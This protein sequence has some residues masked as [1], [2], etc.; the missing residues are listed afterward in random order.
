MASRKA[1]TSDVWGNGVYVAPAIKALFRLRVLFLFDFSW[2]GADEAI[3]VSVDAGVPAVIEEGTASFDVEA[4]GVGSATI[5]ADEAA[6]A[7]DE[8]EL[9]VLFQDNQLP[10]I[11]FH[12]R[13]YLFRAFGTVSFLAHISVRPS[14]FHAPGR[15]SSLPCRHKNHT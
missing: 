10:K 15:R 9:G 5:G 8:E 4:A 6:W 3:L 14:P 13:A 1:I 7:D 2:S 12:I 11:E